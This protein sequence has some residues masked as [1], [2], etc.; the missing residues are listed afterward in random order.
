MRASLVA[1]E[2]LVAGDMVSV[3][4]IFDGRVAKTRVTGSFVESCCIGMAQNTTAAGNIVV[5][6]TDGPS[7]SNLYANQLIPGED[8]YV[9]IAAQLVTF[10]QL[11][12]SLQG[13]G[14]SEAYL[15]H[16]G[17]AASTDQIAIDV[18]QAVYV[19]PSSL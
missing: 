18:E 10:D 9:G 8:Y 11:R 14:Y 7:Q 15:V 13:G 16:A 6:T 2:D 17:L 4:E 12:T 3:K 5:V 1:Y 19:I